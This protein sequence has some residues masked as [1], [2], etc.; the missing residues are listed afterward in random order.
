MCGFLMVCATTPLHLWRVL[1]YTLT[2]IL[3]HLHKNRALVQ[4]LC[5]SPRLQLCTTREFGVPLAWPRL[6]QISTSKI[7]SLASWEIECRDVTVGGAPRHCHART[8]C[9]LFY[10]IDTGSTRSRGRTWGLPVYLSP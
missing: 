3:L 6:V 1:L 5:P 10:V 9:F 4:I 2:A 8:V 7:A